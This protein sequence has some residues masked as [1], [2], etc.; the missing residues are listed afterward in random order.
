MKV[1]QGKPAG[2]RDGRRNRLRILQRCTIYRLVTL[3]AIFLAIFFVTRTFVPIL[4]SSYSGYMLY[5]YLA[6]IG[7]AGFFVI[8]TISQ[9]VYGIVRENSSAQARSARS[10]VVLVGYLLVVAI[11]IS[12]LAQNPTVTVV[13]GTVTG[14][15]LGISL[16]S[17]IGNAVAGLVLAMIRPFR[18]GDTITVFGN[19]GDVYDIGL[20]YTILITQDGNTVLAPNASLLTTPVIRGKRDPQAKTGEAA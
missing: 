9:L 17:L 12:I 4:L 14:L 8:R 7:I 5:F 6:E 20:L 15:V 1:E 11:A 18:I 10:M 3:A 2:R 13:I 19:T 16:Q